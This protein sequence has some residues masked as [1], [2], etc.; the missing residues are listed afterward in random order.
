MDYSN[1][2]GATPELIRSGW[3]SG[4]YE[5]TP[6]DLMSDAGQSQSF[7]GG[8]GYMRNNNLNESD[9]R[10]EFRANTGSNILST[11]GAGAAFGSAF[12]PWG[13]AI[14][15]VGGAIVGGVGS[16]FRGKS[17]D[18]K[19]AEAKNNNFRI[20]TVNESI[21]QSQAMR[22][23]WNQSFL[24]TYNQVRYAA[25]GIDANAYGQK[26]ET[27]Y[28]TEGNAKQIKTG[29]PGIDNV[30]LHLTDDMGVITNE[31][32]LS[33][34]ANMY[35]AIQEYVSGRMQQIG[36]LVD[37]N[38]KNNRNLEIAQN[39]AKGS[40]EVKELLALNEYAKDGIKNV[41]NEQIM[42]R[43]AGLIPRGDNDMPIH[44]AAGWDSVG[45]N[46]ASGLIGAGQF[47]SAYGQKIKNPYTYRQN[48]YAPQAFDTL[49][50]INIPMLPIVNQMKDAIA[51]EHQGIYN[52]GGLSSSQKLAANV[53][54]T[55]NSQSNIAKTM[56]DYYKQ[57]NDI[58]AKTAQ[59]KL[60]EGQHAAQMM[61]NAAQ[62]DL[63]YYSKAH[64]AR[65]D[66][67]N[68]GLYN[69]I[70]SLRQLVADADKRRRFDAMY[71]LYQQ[72]LDSNNPIAS[73][74]SNTTPKGKTISRDPDTLLVAPQPDSHLTRAEQ[75]TFMPSTMVQ[76]PVNS[77]AVTVTAPA[78]N[79]E[80]RRY[81]K[82]TKKLRHANVNPDAE[83][84]YNGDT[85]LASAQQINS[86][87]FKLSPS[88]EKIVPAEVKEDA[89]KLTKAQRKALKKLQ[90]A[91]TANTTS[92][93]YRDA[94]NAVDKLYNRSINKNTTYDYMADGI[95][96]IY[97]IE[98][99][100]NKNYNSDYFT[101]YKWPLMFKH[102]R[103]GSLINNDLRRYYNNFDIQ[104]LEIPGE[105]GRSDFYYNPYVKRT[106]SLI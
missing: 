35:A 79:R 74:A 34:K 10:S 38:I 76:T 43:N 103:F 31:N 67:M 90:K 30:P 29:T 94:V 2:I 54:L 104:Q 24:D 3:Q 22:N 61:Q 50:R 68:I 15:A 5:Y 1:L 47:A 18:R 23:N 13:T 81:E 100:N 28:D 77:P 57:L 21:A 49:D 101:H 78:T 41:A 95:P 88:G 106:Y 36:A 20:N 56:F 105:E 55:S 93:E 11:M 102:D 69:T 89:N 40:K 53:A 73:T 14:G 25:K 44:A 32:G 27:L 70:G 82:M 39:V 19:I 46:L 87:L 75:P 85:P 7:I 72:S 91:N 9:I 97:G 83:N 37:K 17:M 26:D 58:K 86:D 98:R 8:V 60:G 64:A 84:Q 51:K 48:P 4:R 45:V 65:Q 6:Y 71:N 59:L 80:Q 42:Q 33:N 62:W 66:M 96:F 92:S 52:S 99:R 12:G 16:I 63:D